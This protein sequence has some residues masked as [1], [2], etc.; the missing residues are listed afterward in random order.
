MRENLTLAAASQIRAI[1]R[2]AQPDGTW[3]VYEP[4]DTL[5]PPPPPGPPPVPDSITKRQLYLALMELGWFGSTM[6]Q[7]NAQINALLDQLPNPPRERARAEFFTSRDYLRGH[8]LLNAMVTS[9][10]LSK[11]Q[12]DLD[13]LFTLG[14]TFAPE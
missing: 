13:V 11:T 2:V 5:P 10:P 14:A 4:G 12:A 7:I 1:A 9:P 3:T 8:Q 6:D